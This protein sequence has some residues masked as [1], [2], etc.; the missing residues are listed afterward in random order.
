M[1]VQ[2]AGCMPYSNSISKVKQGGDERM[3]ITHDLPGVF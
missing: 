2:S 3:A 1:G